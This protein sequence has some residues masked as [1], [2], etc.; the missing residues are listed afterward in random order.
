MDGLDISG[1]KIRK[2][3]FGGGNQMSKWRLVQSKWRIVQEVNLVGGG[4][5]SVS[6]D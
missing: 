3:E 5:W 1:D 2:V 6:R 4:E